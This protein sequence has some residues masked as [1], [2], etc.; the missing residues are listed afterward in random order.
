[1]KAIKKKKKKKKKSRKVNNK[2]AQVISGSALI[3]DFEN[4]KHASIQQMDQQWLIY[5]HLWRGG[6]GGGS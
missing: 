2:T 5:A 1:M 4:T 3:W 6:G